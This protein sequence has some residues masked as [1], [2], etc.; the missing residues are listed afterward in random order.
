MKVS[1]GFSLL[2]ILV[3]LL[4]IGLFSALSVAWLDSGHAP[5]L[6]ALEKLAAE[7]RTQAAQAR[8]SGQVSGMR[9]NGRQPEFVRKDQTRWVVDRSPMKSWPE[10]LQADWPVSD[11]PR[12][13][14]TPSGV[15]TAVNLNWHWPEGRQ[16]W[17]WR[18]DNSLTQVKLP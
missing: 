4:I 3:V 16:R 1:Q 17:E 14:F 13:I 8:H 9:W 7:A 6:Q 2:E 11:E 18:T 10:G 12:V 5:M 15:A